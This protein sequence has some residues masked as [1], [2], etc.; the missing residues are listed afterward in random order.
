MSRRAEKLVR[1]LVKVVG[2]SMVIGSGYL[3][4]LFTTI[5]NI[6]YPIFA[7]LMTF[8][9]AIMVVGSIIALLY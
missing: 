6:P 5:T 4:Y 2:L 8:F 3:A 7:A 1:A 9:I